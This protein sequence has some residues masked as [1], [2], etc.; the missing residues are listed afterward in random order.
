MNIPIKRAADI[1]GHAPSWRPRAAAPVPGAGGPVEEFLAAFRNHPAG[2]GVI[3]ADPGDGPVALTA[4]SVFSVSAEPAV[5]AFSVSGSSSAA[6]GILR[7]AS[8]VVHL[9][10]TAQVALARLCA[11]SGVDRFADTGAWDRLTTG[12]PY[13]PRVD[14]WIRARITDR[15]LAGSGTLVVAQATAAW[16]SADGV[17][18]APLVYHH[19][20]WHQLGESSKLS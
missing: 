14:S 1:D 15:V 7:S 4:T 8:V 16:I 5:L 20:S 3:T 6:P 2:V 9:L 13:F 12:E 17:P 11:T 10:G 19:R 18:S